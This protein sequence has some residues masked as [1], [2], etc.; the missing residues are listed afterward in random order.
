MGHDGTSYIAVAYIIPQQ[1]PSHALHRNV[2]SH[3]DDMDIDTTSSRTW[4]HWQESRSPQKR[5]GQGMRSNFEGGGR[6]GMEA[7]R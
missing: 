6:G 2:V 5:P 7:L 1:V 4:S 3:A